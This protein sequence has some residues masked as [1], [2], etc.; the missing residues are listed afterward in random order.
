M[1][2]YGI[3][4]PVLDLLERIEEEL[5]AIAALADTLQGQSAA[6]VP[7]CAP[8][9]FVDGLKAAY[10]ARMR[11]GDLFSEQDRDL[12]RLASEAR[13]EPLIREALDACTRWGLAV[14]NWQRERASRFE[15]PDN[16]WRPFVANVFTTRRTHPL[17]RLQRL[18]FKRVFDR[19]E[20]LYVFPA[21]GIDSEFLDDRRDFVSVA[22]HANRP[23]TPDRVR[24][25][26]LGVTAQELRPEDLAAAEERFGYRPDA[27]RAL[28]LKGVQDLLAADELAAF[29]ERVHPSE[30]VVFG[31]AATG[32]ARRPAGVPKILPE[33]REALAAM[34]FR[35]RTGAV[36]SAP[37]L[38]ALARV[39]ALLEQK[40]AW[41]V[42]HFPASEVAVLT[43]AAAPGDSGR[44]LTPTLG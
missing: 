40:L 36:F 5:L 17:G 41:Q 2:G 7:E 13:R 27:P 18:L 15:P 11:T 20:G 1:A 21:M 30:I 33:L 25:H 43:R 23:R 10:R 34:G 35:D 19:V 44:L 16:P 31:C 6:V 26:H 28:V 42:G 22:P 32:F 4:A 12:L 29:V 14:T 3:M 8:A 39:H 37:E 24:V 38:E 9:S